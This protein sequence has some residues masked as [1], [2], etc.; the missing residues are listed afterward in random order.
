MRD[1]YVWHKDKLKGEYLEV[2]DKIELYGGMTNM[3]RFTYEERMMD[4]VD[5]FVSAQK[6]GKMVGKIV[7]TDI[8]KFCESYFSEYSWKDRLKK[9]PERYIFTVW[10]LFVGGILDFWG[11]WLNAVEVS[12][13]TIRSDIGPFV[14]VVLIGFI[15]LGIIETI[16]KSFVFKIK[17]LSAE[18]YSLVVLI[19]LFASFFLFADYLPEMEVPTW[20]M[21]L[22]S[23]GYIL[24]YYGGKVYFNFKKYG[25]FKNMEQVSKISFWGKVNEGVEIEWPKI[26]KKRYEKINKNLEK[27]SRLPMSRD[28]YMIKVRK[29]ATLDKK[30][31]LVGVIFIIVLCVGISIF[32]IIDAGLQNGLL[33]SGIL[34]LVEIPIVK[35]MWS[36]YK[37]NPR[38]KVLKKCDELGMDVI[39]YAKHL[40]NE[41]E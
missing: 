16:L 13:W 9:L 28:D 17:W 20:I 10:L 1:T 36:G 2:F 40:E 24:L 35:W 15:L 37:N 29:E 23:G 26:L 33:F 32:Q 25:T 7:G 18:N 27:K 3:D 12:L 39:E 34:C 30:G 41:I 6:H 22:V 11:V 38:E 8:E 31:S 21:I 4:L 14:A 5:M 19:I